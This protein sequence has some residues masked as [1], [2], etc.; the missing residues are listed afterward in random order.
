MSVLEAV[1]FPVDGAHLF[2]PGAGG[3]MPDSGL[4]HARS[5]ARVDVAVS[6]ISQ[7]IDIPALYLSGG[8]TGPVA[9]SE[10]DDMYDYLQ[11]RLG[12]GAV[13]PP[14][15]R[16]RQAERSFQNLALC[17]P[18]FEEAGLFEG[19]QT[20]AIVTDKAHMRRILKIAEVTLPQTVAILPVVDEYRASA[21]QIGRE[22]VARPVTRRILAGLPAG[23]GP[24][25]VLIKEQ[26]YAGHKGRVNRVLRR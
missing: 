25:V 18:L 22:L 10:A 23:A 17:V 4:L 13:T 20:L 16:E 24:E 12:S 1:S 21:Y 2:I 5:A 26:E 19:R 14:V 15:Y 8:N 6:A 7:S 11:S 9:G 3:N